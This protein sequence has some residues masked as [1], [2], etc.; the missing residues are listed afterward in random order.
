MAQCYP[1]ITKSNRPIKHVSDANPQQ[2]TTLSGVKSTYI[3]LVT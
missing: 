3:K 2:K 1:P